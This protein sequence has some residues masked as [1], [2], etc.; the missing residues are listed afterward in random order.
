[1]EEEGGL[2]AF[3]RNVGGNSED[4]GFSYLERMRYG[5]IKYFPIFPAQLALVSH[6]SLVVCR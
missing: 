5:K 6:Y 1:V 2:S 4:N 3:V